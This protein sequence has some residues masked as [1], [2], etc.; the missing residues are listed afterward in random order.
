M[1]SGLVMMMMMLHLYITK[2]GQNGLANVRGRG[3][4]DGPNARSLFE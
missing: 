3:G 1:L 2:V 4:G